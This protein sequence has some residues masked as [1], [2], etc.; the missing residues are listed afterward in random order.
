[1]I[2][3]PK[4]SAKESA[5]KGSAKKLAIGKNAYVFALWGRAI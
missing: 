1:M 2:L 5:R 4:T 3:T